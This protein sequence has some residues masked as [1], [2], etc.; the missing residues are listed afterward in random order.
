MTADKPADKPIYLDYA[1][2]TPADP[3]VVEAMQRALTH[4]GNFGNPASRQHAFGRSAAQAVE[5]AREQVAEAINAEPAEIIW[6]SGATESNNL[7]IKG[8]AE[9]Y[10]DRG[11]HLITL[12]TEHKSVVD[13]YRQ[14]EQAGWRVTWL[15]PDEQGR[16]APQQLSDAIT[17][18]ITQETVLVS[19]MAVNNE[20]GV[21]QD[22]EA[23][24]RVTAEHGVLLHVDAAQALGKIPVDVSAWQADLVSVSAHKCYGPKGIGALYVRRQPRARLKAQMHGGGHERGLRSGTLPTHQIVG[25]GQACALLRQN[26]SAE[27]ARI[28]ALHERL[29]SGLSKLP[30]VYRNGSAQHGVGH[31]LN[32]SFA[33]VDGEAL[34][35]GLAPMMAVSSGSACTAASQESSYVLRA[36]GRDD[37]LAYASVRLSLGRWTSEAE[38]DAVIEHVQA[39]VGYLRSLSPHWVS[40]YEHSPAMPAEDAGH[41][42]YSTAAW[43]YFLDGSR[44][45]YW[46]DEP[47]VLS[48]QAQ[49]PGSRAMLQLQARIENECIADTRFQVYGCVSAIA[50]GAWLA[51]WLIG[52]SLDEL[53]TLQASDIDTALALAPVK[54]HCALLAEDGL[55]IIEQEWRQSINTTNTA[56]IKAR[57]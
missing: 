37:E 3:V 57:A 41:P 54:R 38:I 9:A 6:T 52:K 13:C 2:T 40:D 26:L 34:H 29:W 32:L 1:A 10:A 45:G 36:L 30:E 47:S 48:A 56:E 17:Q 43:R 39:H 11:R 31:I 7:A 22:L 21:M 35:A 4:D 28:Q 55:R 19:V 42:D 16:L 8:A 33:G 49:T 5:Q 15:L 23:L 25:F 14:L 50:C 44:V 12:K 53:N 24:G 51:Q 46:V 27:R 20:T 18:A